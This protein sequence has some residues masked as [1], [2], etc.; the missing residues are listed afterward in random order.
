MVENHAK[1]AE[2]FS[3]EGKNYIDSK[4]GDLSNESNKKGRKLFVK[5]ETLDTIHRPQI[6]ENMNNSQ[7]TIS[8]Q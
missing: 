8:S 5:K 7:L 4:Y 6:C 2:Q 3:H 1:A